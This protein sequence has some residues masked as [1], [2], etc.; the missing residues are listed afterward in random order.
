MARERSDPW[1]GAF[2]GAPI[3]VGVSACLLGEEVRFDGGHKRSSFLTDTLAR[4][5]EF[6]PVC[7]EVELGLGVPRLSLRLVGEPS[8]PRLVEPR[9]GADH[10]TAM[11][12]FARERAG[13]LALDDLCGFVLKKDSP[14]CGMERVRVHEPGRPPGRPPRRTGQGLF[15]TALARALPFLP[16]EEEGRLQDPVLREGFVVRL[17]AQRR[18][19]DVFGRRW[20]LADAVSFHA[21]EKL[22]LLAHDESAYRAL[23]RLVARAK[24]LPRAEFARAYQEGFT[25]ALRRRA[26]VRRHANVLQHVLGHFKRI[27]DIA[28]RREIERSIEDYRGGLV[29]LIVP[30]TLL[31]YFVRR[32]EIDWLAAQTYLNPHPKELM[33]RNHV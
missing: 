27:D 9:T 17:F 33:L 12:A 4:Y 22:L 5:V 24:E 21:S 28:G 6:V 16:L 29:P 31:R 10:T 11:E 18:L 15:A 25:G 30:I 20:S 8:A 26:T 7:P 32:Y 2:P 23:G 1:T 13:A 19:K 14:S 3:R